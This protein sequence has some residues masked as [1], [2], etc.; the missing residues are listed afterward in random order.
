MSKPQ[1]IITSSGETLVILPLAEYEA[2][3]DAA[4]GADEDAADVAAYDAA[5][6]ALAIG[7]EQMLPPEVCGLVLNGHSRLRA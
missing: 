7:E 3:L 2:L 6:A 5:K 1:T 4:A